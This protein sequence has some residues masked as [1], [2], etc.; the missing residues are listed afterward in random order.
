[1]AGA[2]TLH[3]AACKV[4]SPDGVATQRA[5]LHALPL[6]GKGPTWAS[7]AMRRGRRTVSQQG[8]M[9]W[10]LSVSASSMLWLQ[11]N[12]ALKEAPVRPTGSAN[13]VAGYLTCAMPAG[14]GFAW[15]REPQSTRGCISQ[16][17]RTTM[18][19]C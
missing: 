1:M 17:G 9:M 7:G 5:A 10:R 12:S 2:A 13:W 8:P 3:D 18:P 11:P 14:E 19:A 15:A 6:P 4:A 16:A